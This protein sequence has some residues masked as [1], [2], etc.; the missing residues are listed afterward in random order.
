MIIVQNQQ[1]FMWH[2]YSFHEAVFFFFLVVCV[3]RGMGV[4]GIIIKSYQNKYCWVRVILLLTRR[5]WNMLRYRRKQ[6]MHTMRCYDLFREVSSN[7]RNALWLNNEN[8]GDDNDDCRIPLNRLIA[9]YVINEFDMAYYRFLLF[10]YNCQLHTHTH[11]RFL[12]PLFHLDSHL[13]E[14]R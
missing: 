5:I 8:D 10:P 2:E 13:H 12:P 14:T 4:L 7:L 11:H 9:A 6:Y 1:N 3:V